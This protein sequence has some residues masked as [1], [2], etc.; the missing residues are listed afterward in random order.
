MVSAARDRNL[1]NQWEEMTCFGFG[2]FTHFTYLPF[3]AAAPVR[4]G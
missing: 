2:F 3:F 1:M 4:L